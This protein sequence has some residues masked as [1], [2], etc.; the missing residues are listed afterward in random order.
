[1]ELVQIYL[2]N[3]N[4]IIVIITNSHFRCCSP[5]LFK[6]IP[7]WIRIKIQ[8]GKLMWIRIWNHSPVNYR[9]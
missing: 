6:E 2:K 4:E 5:F 1:M 8:E 9:L 7:S 3:L